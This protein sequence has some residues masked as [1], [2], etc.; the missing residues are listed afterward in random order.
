[1]RISD[2]HTTTNSD[3]V[4]LSATVDKLPPEHPVEVFF[5]FRVP[6]GN[7]REAT[8]DA[9]A[10]ALLLPSMRAGEPLEIVP[11]LSSNLCFNLPRIQD[12]FHTWWPHFSRVPI[13]ATPRI[14]NA[15]AQRTGGATFFS[16]GVDSFYSLLK[17]RHG[18]GGLS[19]LTHIIFMRGIETRLELSKGV[20]EAEAWVQ[21]IAAAT[22]VKCITGASNIRTSLQGPE[23]NLHWEQHYHGSAL[24]AVALA[25]PLNLEYVC[26]PSTFS[27]NHLAV[28]GSTALVDEMYS[29]ENLHLV[30]DGS[31][32]TRAEKV[33][34][35]LEW[36]RDV[37]LKYLRVCTRNSG[38][39]YNCGECY[40]CVRTAIP[41]RI[42]G[43][44]DEV[45][46]FQNKS[47]AHWEEVM[48]LDHFF[49]LTEENLQFA[50]KYGTDAELTAMLER[51]VR[52][53]RR[54]QG[55]VRFMENSPL[56]QLLPLARRIAHR[57]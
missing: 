53:R 11:P 21:E 34:R 3:I 17:H 2:I 48:Q 5:E 54:R 36:D 10:A 57:V 19:P 16:G 49:V 13:S 24:A 23:T 15:P 22:G 55:A 37:V 42:L 20:D 38:G 25:I 27:Y 43:V 35:I 51:V 33:A 40:K 41:L 7:L 47:T 8:V 44:W 1:M 26:I 14:G 50:R 56:D 45:T 29:T 28:H 39:A 52:R 9:F 31:E 32:V 30:H 4:R 18:A 46:T 6:D 12:V